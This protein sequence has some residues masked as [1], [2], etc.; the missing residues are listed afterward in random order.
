MYVLVCFKLAKRSHSIHSYRLHLSSHPSRA[1][2]QNPHQPGL[3]VLQ[4]LHLTSN[5]IKV[6]QLGITFECYNSLQQISFTVNVP[7]SVRFW[8]EKV[9]FSARHGTISNWYSI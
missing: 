4:L 9:H 5:Q 1:L 8:H 3:K 6:S 2:R 7:E